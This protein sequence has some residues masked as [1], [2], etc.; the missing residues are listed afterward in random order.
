M[1]FTKFVLTLFLTVLLS[2][3]LRAQT[4]VSPDTKFNQSSKR[5]VS[6]GEN[7]Q[8]PVSTVPNV[9][10][11]LMQQYISAGDRYNDEE[12]LRLS[13]Q[14][15]KFLEKTDSKV[16][17]PSAYEIGFEENPG[18]DWYEEDVLVNSGDVGNQSFRQLDMQQGDDGR[19][20]LGLVRR[21]V[22]GFNGS[23]RVFLSANGGATWPSNVFW[24]YNTYYI[25]SMSMLVESRNNSIP[26][27]TRILIYF[28][29]STNANFN[30]ARLYL[31]SIR[32]DLTASYTVEVAAPSPGNKFTYVSA[33]S[34]GIFY[35]SATAIHA[36]VRE[37]TN[38][39]SYVRLH[40]FRSANFGQTHSG[41][42]LTTLNDDRYP[43]IAFSNEDGA[44]SVYIAVERHVAATEWEIRLI[45]TSE[46][47][48]TAFEVSYV[49]D[50]VAGI[51]YER[52]SIS[53]Q[54][55]HY[56]LP[57]QVL[58]T[59]TKNDRAVYHGSTNGGAGWIVDYTLGLSTQAVDYTSCNSDTL[60]AGGG[61]FVAAYVDING[62][63][64]TVRRG[65]LG[66]LGITQHK[67]NSYTST[68]ILA[69]I[70]A[71]YKNGSDKYSAL[72]Y[73]GFG[74]TNVFFNSENLITG[75]TQTGTS[76][77]SGY[78]LGQNYPNPFN[79]VTNVEFALPKS[80]IV[81]LSVYDILG[82]EM[83]VIVN[84][85]L[86]AGTYKADWNASNFPSGVY[87][88]KL[89]SD[90]FVDTKKMILVK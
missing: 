88:Y 62:D 24:N 15:D 57:Q 90:G 11:N 21:N 73:S 2:N 81:K 75:I 76:V 5:Q 47:P 37:E 52:P 63:S 60:T 14:I 12:R 19:L 26:D 8:L 69:P 10:Q 36:V 31:F 38:A 42:T 65:V 72:A 18:S 17:E 58:V 41:A 16:I 6:P 74:P 66:N 3:S 70:C 68:G 28:I 46:I 53:I 56:S 55:R 48:S 30:D 35:T 86:T 4:D 25:H 80:S 13:E 64:V 23:L 51:M 27:S 71:I 49:T 20:Y 54:Q 50:A 82:N 85:F 9:P 45:T 29:G 7:I 61:Y 59:C 1:Y 89:E 33:C 22:A 79:P 77:P 78:K 87:F 34:D 39:G 83:E 43:S 44:D 40:H 84:E 32:R 67:R